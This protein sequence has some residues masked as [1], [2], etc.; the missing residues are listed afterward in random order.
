MNDIQHLN[1]E[2]QAAKKHLDELNE[3]QNDQEKFKELIG[4]KALLASW[5]LKLDELPLKSKQRLLQGL[6]DG[7]IVIYPASYLEA[8][9]RLDIKPRGP[10][11]DAVKS[12]PNFRFNQP[13]LE[14]ILGLDKYL[15]KS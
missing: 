11:F 10:L 5:W 3:M 1:Q 9:K 15:E 7:P 13:I 2:L 12:K 14:E 8:M 6:L 4:N